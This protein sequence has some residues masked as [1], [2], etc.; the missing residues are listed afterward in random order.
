MET[1]KIDEVDLKIL[2]LL[3]SDGRMSNAKIARSLQLGEVPCWRRIRCLE[4]SGYITS[5]E[6]LVNQNLLGYGFHAFVHLKVDIASDEANQVFRNTI[7][8]FPEVLGFHNT[9]GDFDY[10]LFVVT[11]DVRNFS[12]FVEERLRGHPCGQLI[13][14]IN[15]S[16]VLDTIKNDARIDLGV[17]HNQP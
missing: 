13:S 1:Y 16:V 12:K 6:T 7:S 15:S 5:Y 4:D 2:K 14:R 8:Q 17:I 10:V 3:Q 9:T 11:R